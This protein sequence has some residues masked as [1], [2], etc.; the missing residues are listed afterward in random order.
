MAYVVLI[1]SLFLLLSA[2]T[3]L[4]PGR[5]G[6]LKMFAFPVG[7]AAGELA[8]QA[9]GAELALLG[10]LWLWGWPR[11]QWLG[12]AVLSVAVV[13]CIANCVLM[14]VQLTSQRTVAT[15]M[16]SAPRRPLSI[17]GPRDDQFGAWWRTLLQVPWHPKSMVLLRNIPY[18]PQPRQ[19]LDV[20]RLST[21]PANA[22]VIFYV[23]GGGWTMGD[24]AEQGRPFLHEMVRRGWMVVTI[25]YHLAPKNLWP[26]QIH[27][28]VR[29][30]GWV[31]GSIGAMGGD[32]HRVVVA[33]ASAGGHLAALLALSDRDPTWR[34]SNMANVTDWSVRG[35]VSYYGV[36]EMTGDPQIWN[37]H[38]R[39]LRKFLERFVVGQLLSERADLYE[40][41]SPVRRITPEAPPF[42]V[43]H[44]GNDTVVDVNVAR[45][46]VSTFEKI[47]DAPIYYV[48]IPL[49]QHAFDVTASP[50][51]SAVTRAS[52]AFCES[53]IA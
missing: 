46:F 26:A 34:P 23:H 27:D 32:P 25:N 44:G 39:D 16:R 42:L 28:V 35:C 48:E 9:V 38:G 11:T 24:K 5:Q 3:A 15:A 6:F 49:T 17:G 40:S 30:L 36:L 33:G 13:T 50:R 7:W 10:V 43:I 12:I 8:V 53:V 45:H 20:W 22:P 14:G 19:R 21:T 1:I 47:A 52:V 2:G 41:L 18:G 37:G 31:K 4:R 51:T 29:A